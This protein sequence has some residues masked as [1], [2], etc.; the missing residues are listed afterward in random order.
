MTTLTTGFQKLGSA[1]VLTDDYGELWVNIYARYTSLD[2][3]NKKAY[4]EYKAQ[5]DYTSTYIQDAGG[6]LSVSGTGSG[7]NSTGATYISGSSPISTTASGTIGYD[8]NGRASGS[9][10][11]TLSMPNWSSSNTASGSFD[12]PSIPTYT[13]SYNA[14]GGSGA[15]GSQTKLQDNTLTLSSS[16]PTRSYYTFAGWATSSTGSVAYAAGASYKENASR[17]L[18][19]VWNPYT[20]TVKYNANG[21]TGAPANQTKTYNK[22]LTLS[23]AKPT[24][25]GYTFGGW[26]TSAGGSKSY[27]AGGSYTE[28]P[29]ANGAIINLYAVWIE[30]KLTV[31]YYSNYATASFSNPKNAIGSDKNVIVRVQDFGYATKCTDGLANYTEPANVAY[32]ARTGYN[33]TGNWGTSTYGGNIVNQDTAFNTGQDL[34]VA[35]GKTLASDNASVNIYPQ[36]QIKTYTVSY[37]ANEGTGAPDA[38]TK[39]HFTDLILSDVVP[40]RERYDFLG[41]STSPTGGVIYQP[42]D[43]YTAEADVTLYAIWELAASRV[44]V[45]DEGGNA[46]TGL[47]YYY[48]DNGVQHYAIITIY[49]SDGNPHSVI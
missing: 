47:C 1:R 39:T 46:H 18:Y 13:I 20:Y 38:Q 5:T 37:N 41:W 16:K 2:Y 24:R 32:L 6:S 36:W 15:P 33:A 44:T 35:L 19:A 49:D 28:N 8:G 21:G 42:G 30:N 25:T 9:A 29:S 43:T 10:S 48:D 31:N 23:S 45:Y 22:T 4:V 40:T 27:D 11:G 14:N 7:G 12:I 34:A 17:T 26:A 3:A